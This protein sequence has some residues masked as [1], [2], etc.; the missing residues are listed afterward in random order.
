VDAS[1]VAKWVLPSESHQENAVKLKEDFIAQLTFLSAPAFITLEVGNALWSAVKLRRITEE[2]AQKALRA[3]SDMKIELHEVD[4]VQVS[5]GLRIACKL[6]LTVY[7]AAY[8]FLS[9]KMEVNLV[10]ADNN[11]HEKSKKHFEVLHIKNYL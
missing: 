4:W 5:Q 9:Q 6:D 7:D 2:D 8:L 1:V 10:T 3:L 11:L